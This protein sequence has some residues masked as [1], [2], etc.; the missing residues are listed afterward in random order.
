MLEQTA[1]AGR[2][3]DI[4]IA[5]ISDTS[6][7]AFARAEDARLELRILR[8]RAGLT[9]RESEVLDLRLAGYKEAEIADQLG[10]KLGTVKA[11][12]KHAR[13]KIHRAGSPDDSL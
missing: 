3:R 10:V 1:P 8:D 12:A 11:T 5:G 2:G 4:D 7:D 9:A 6:T 13:D